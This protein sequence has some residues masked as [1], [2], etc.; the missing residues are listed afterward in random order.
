VNPSENEVLTEIAHAFSNWDYPTI[1]AF[2]RRSREYRLY[3]DYRRIEDHM[4]HLLELRLRR[5][6]FRSGSSASEGYRSV[7]ERMQG[8]SRSSR[9]DKERKR[10]GRNVMADAVV[11]SFNLLEVQMF[12]MRRDIERLSTSLGLKELKDDVLSGTPQEGGHNEIGI[13]G[14]SKEGK[15][16]GNE[17]QILDSVI[18]DSTIVQNRIDTLMVQFGNDT[19]VSIDGLDSIQRMIEDSVATLN[20]ALDKQVITIKQLIGSLDPEAIS[21]IMDRLPSNHPLRTLLD[22]LGDDPGPHDTTSDR[23]SSSAARTHSNGSVSGKISVKGADGLVQT[24]GDGNSHPGGMDEISKGHDR[25]SEGMDP[26]DPEP[27]LK[28]ASSCVVDSDDEE[29]SLSMTEVI[30]E[31][32][33]IFT[34]GHGKQP[35]H[36]PG[37]LQKMVASAAVLTLMVL[38]ISILSNL[39]MDTQ[40]SPEGSLDMEMLLEGGDVLSTEV[41]NR[42]QFSITGVDFMFIIPESTYVETEIENLN[43]SRNGIDPDDGGKVE[44]RY[45]N[46][47]LGPMGPSESVFIESDPISGLYFDGNPSSMFGRSIGYHFEY[48]DIRAQRISKQGFFRT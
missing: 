47:S 9:S 31:P 30:D 24:S 22:D 14:D 43:I 13:T 7:N 23:P 28:E 17:L 38:F 44:A 29:N 41:T 34:G 37:P 2:L 32:E 45:L 18:R 26:P 11:A 35:S 15:A 3:P 46:Y 5:E 6:V 36:R 12:Y 4:F 16:S 39:A 25:S 10:C 40:Q 1:F 48:I 27:A 21:P 42:H 19:P 20:E 33:E 8:Y